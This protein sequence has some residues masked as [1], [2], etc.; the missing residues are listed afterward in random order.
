MA[1]TVDPVVAFGMCALDLAM[2]AKAGQLRRG[3]ALTLSARAARDLPQDAEAMAAAARFQS[4]VAVDPVVAGIVLHDWLTTWRTGRQ[5]RA[6][7]AT[8]MQRHAWQDRADING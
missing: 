2:Q 4:E 8:P 6:V 3:A 7:M 5:H 1:D